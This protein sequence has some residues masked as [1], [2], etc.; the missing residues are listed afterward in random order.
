[1]KRIKA[2]QMIEYNRKKPLIEMNENQSTIKPETE[3]TNPFMRKRNSVSC[4]YEGKIDVVLGSF[5]ERKKKI[6]E[7]LSKLKQTPVI[8]SNTLRI[9]N[10]PVQLKERTPRFTS[11]AGTEKDPV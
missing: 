6:D 9:D 5:E 10:K 2:S 4:Y 3:S 8:T 1:M 11:L 7:E